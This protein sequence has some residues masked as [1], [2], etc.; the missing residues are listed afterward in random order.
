[1]ARNVFIASTERRSG[2]SLF[3][4]G[5][6]GA[7]QGIVPKV[8]YMK[9]IGQGST[10]KGIED[11]DARLVKEVF[12]LDDDFAHMCPMG[13]DR[14]QRDKDA[15][16]ERIFAC[17]QNIATGKDIV[18]LEGTDYTSSV[19]ALEFDIN[20]ELAKNLV[21]PVLLVVKGEDK[22]IDEIARSVRE[23][24]RSFT[25]QGCTL[26]GTLVNRY[27]STD[28]ERDTQRISEAL[29]KEGVTL[30]GVIL[31]NPMLSG[32]R[33]EEVAESLGAKVLFQGDDLSKIVTATRI[34]AMTPENALGYMKDQNGYLLVTPGDRSEHIFTVISAQKSSHFPKYSG[35]VLTGGIPIGIETRRLIDGIDDVDLSILSVGEDTFT[36][37]RNVDQ[38]S[39]E[40][41]AN[42]GEKIGLALQA[43]ERYVDVDEIYRR[44]GAIRTDITTPRMFQYRILEVAK[45]QKKKIVLPEGSEIRILKAAEEVH[46][47]EICDFILLGDRKEI[48][49]IIE[50]NNIAVDPSCITDVALEEAKREEYANIFYELRKHKGVALEQARDSMLD[51]VVY[52]AMMVYTGEADG[53]VS[54]ST[55]S[56]ADTLRPVLQIIKTKSEVSLASSVFFMCMPDQV[57]VYGDCA[58][59]SNP[60]SEELADIAVTSAETAK[61]F[62]I[63]PVVAMLSYSTGE[64]GKGTD[65]DR[66][67][68][69]AEIAK[70]KR[71]NL[72]IE[73]PIQYDAATS[74][75]VAAIKAKGSSVAGKATVYIFPDLDAGNT[76]YKAVQRSAN[77]PAIGPVMQG[78]NKPAND[79]SRGA[80]VTDI[81]YTIAITAIQAQRE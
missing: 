62:G 65:V 54:G 15:L 57:I 38:I 53:Y 42:D 63:D 37:A 36:T 55:H 3:A 34:L 8:G 66:V 64:S 32:A 47:R 10:E 21:A 58:L 71:P 46:H 27:K 59:V 45:S 31:D 79:L 69:A 7:L 28:P 74:I 41:R 25:E 11:E 40:L 9:P 49:G 5:L 80:T 16:F 81:V 22:G 18:V 68:E 13:M 24:A 56:T 51:P 17:Y 67:R 1:M 35:I 48:L 76:A 29:E 78:L 73:G 4:L 20:A 2:K 60:S 14:A 52:A 19:S 43:V 30:Y 39:G 12:N 75:E 61:S 33:L 70:K 44:M 77:V 23:V 26:I 6:I 50:K 72:P